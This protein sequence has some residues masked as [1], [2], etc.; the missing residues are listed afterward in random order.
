V[1]IA[2]DPEL[3]DLA[4][5]SGCMCLSIGFESINQAS[6]RTVGKSFHD[7]TRYRRVIDAVR[8]R[9]IKVNALIMFG[10]DDDHEDVFLR[11]AD[12]FEE[13]GV[14]LLDCFVLVPM[15]GTPVF[16]RLRREG[17]LL[18]ED[19]RQYSVT[20]VVFQPRRM[21]PETLRE[22]LWMA[23]RRFYRYSSIVRRMW[24]CMGG[25]AQEWLGVVAL[26]FLYRRMVYRRDNRHPNI[27]HAPYT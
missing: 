6:L 4:A 16:D 25:R 12:F 23:L 2:D 26:N 13:A 19:V 14:S 20:N 8:R 11:T 9:N 10:F 22:G 18:T 27:W 1:E 24:Q 17:R 15:P 5:A 3:L 21:K 7:V